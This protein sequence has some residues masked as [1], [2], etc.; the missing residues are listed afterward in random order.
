MLPIVLRI[1]KGKGLIEV[2]QFQLD[3]VVIGSPESDVQVHLDDSSVAP[4]HAIIEKR[5]EKYYV[6]DLGSEAGTLLN[7]NR[8]LDS[9]ITS[10]DQIQIGEY[11][12]EFH[13]GVPK[14]KTPPPKV[15]ATAPPAPLKAVTG[16]PKEG[17]APVAQAPESSPTLPEAPQ[18]PKAPAAE[19]AKEEPASF[20]DVEKPPTELAQ[21]VASYKASGGSKR[22]GAGYAPS[23]EFSSIYE[24]VKPSKGTVVEVL[25]VWKERVLQSYHFSE[26]RT[27]TFGPDS[28]AD[29]FV[30]F[31]RGGAK[32]AP[33][34]RIDTQAF[35]L[36]SQGTEGEINDGKTTQKIIELNQGGRLQMTGS[37]YQLGLAQGEMVVLPVGEGLQVA[38][39]YVSHTPR[40][41]PVPWLDLS[42]EEFMAI[43]VAVILTSIFALF[44]KVTAPE[45]MDEVKQEI[46]AR[47]LVTPPAATRP[48]PPPPEIQAPPPREEK[49]QTEVPLPKKETIAEAPRPSPSPGARP[50]PPQRVRPRPNRPTNNAPTSAVR[51]GGAVKTGDTQGAQAQSQTKDI[52]QSGIFSVFGGGG[53]KKQ[54]DQGYTGAGELAGLADSATGRAGEAESRQGE[55]LGSRF[56]DTGAG[57]TGTSNYGVS[58][59]D[60]T[61]SGRGS[62][63]LGYGSQGLGGREGAR[64]VL[65]GSEEEF[66]GTIDRE[67][68]RRVISHHMRAIKACY[69]AA[70]NKDPGLFGKIVMSFEISGNGQAQNV[71]PVPSRSTLHSREVASCLVTRFG[72]MRFPTPPRGQV[73]EVTFPF[74][75]SPQ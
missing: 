35:V 23:S 36:L 8:V 4:I 31:L 37:T 47:V 2:R 48:P 75:F 67:A 65:G 66:E 57:G 51:Q 27:I 15:A 12:L 18:A 26:R 13:Q 63:E 69:Q 38:I 74:V 56:R 5:G 11:V 43:A 62:G 53:Q 30:P 42:S 59:L 40:P 10:G 44:M 58:G 1:Y 54:I 32:R 73:P 24:I 3:Q 39:R 46:V 41:T 7:G 45:E 21:A 72:R 52:S 55:G 19:P 60:I 34:L 17:P 70:L 64:V 6:A 68:I 9:E 61:T 50:S 16:P 25:V 33:L 49:T 28:S 14:P 20:H 29:V 22:R 71:K